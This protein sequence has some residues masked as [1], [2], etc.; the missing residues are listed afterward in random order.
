LNEIA[1]HSAF[2]EK[3]QQQFNKENDK[4]TFNEEQQQ[5]DRED[6]LECVCDN[7]HS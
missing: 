2:A 6:R 1:T 7:K 4:S 3:H 5:D